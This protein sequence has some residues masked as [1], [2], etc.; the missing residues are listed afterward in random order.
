MSAFIVSKRHIDHLVR[1]AVTP[2]YGAERC[3]MSWCHDGIRYDARAATADDV[4]QM[5]WN[6]NIASVES[7]Y[8]HL[9][10]AGD[11]LPGHYVAEA[12]VPGAGDIECAEWA[13]PYRYNI[14]NTRPTDPVEI[15][16][17]IACYEYQACECSSWQESNAKAFCNALRVR[18]IRELPGYDDADWEII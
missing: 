3:G 10:A 7:R 12:T 1:A 11:H 13:R 18:M 5:L 4:G 17:A 15:L 14:L 16:K 2:I 6:A 8:A 9:V